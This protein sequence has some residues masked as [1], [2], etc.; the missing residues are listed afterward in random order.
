MTATVTGS[1]QHRPSQ[2]GNGGAEMTEQFLPGHN[3]ST[4]VTRPD[5]LT[6][7]TVIS[8][9]YNQ[10][11]YLRQSATDLNTHDVGIEPLGSSNV[12]VRYLTE[13]VHQ[14]PSINTPHAYEHESGYFISKR[15]RG[16]FGPGTST[17]PSEAE[18][19]ERFLKEIQILTHGP[20]YWHP[21]IISILGIGWYFDEFSHEPAAQPALIL[22]DVGTTLDDY[23]RLNPK[24]EFSKRLRITCDIAEGLQACHDCGVMHANLTSQSILISTHTPFKS[25]GNLAAVTIPIAKIADFSCAYMNPDLMEPNRAPN[26]LLSTSN[27]GK[28]MEVQSGESTDIFSFGLL[29]W[30]I[31]MP[32]SDLPRFRPESPSNNSSMASAQRLVERSFS[33]IL[34]EVK[35]SYNDD[36]GGTNVDFVCSLLKYSLEPGLSEKSLQR[37]LLG[38]QQRRQAFDIFLPNA[39][40]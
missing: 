1:A 21:N 2:Y 19:F 16:L 30:R 22:E 25:S 9:M 11:P 13:V 39:T 18:A 37:L 34:R 27:K 10:R 8:K 20:L 4:P 26:E 24:L 40:R 31:F 14:L 15:I 7:I 29:V 35:K 5:I 38:L 3:I 28:G 33:A 36:E 23:L 32:K 12:F 6:L 17:R